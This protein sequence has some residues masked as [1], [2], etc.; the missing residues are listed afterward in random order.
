M[1]ERGFEVPEAFCK[2]ALSFLGEVKV[3]LKLKLKMD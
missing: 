1:D 2:F 3:K